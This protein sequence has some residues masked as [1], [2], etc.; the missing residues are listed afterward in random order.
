M[1]NIAFIG[2]GAMGKP[3]AR[4]ILKAGYS[5]TVFDLRQDVV[6]ELAGAGAAGAPTPREAAAGKDIVLLSLP[7]AAVVEQVLIAE[8]GLFAG[9]HP[10]QIFIDLSSVTP[11]HTRKMAQL[12]GEKGVGYLDA[13]V[14][15]G[16]AGAAAGTL[17][18][19]VGG[20]QAI[21]EKCREVLQTIGKKIYHVGPAGAGDTMKLIN[22]LLL[23]VNMAAVAEALTLG[24]K[25]ELDPATM[26]EIISVS[27]GR[28]YALEAKV[29]AFILKGNFAPGFAI[30]LQHKDLAM[31]IQTAKELAVPV[32]L[33]NTAQT[34]YETAQD[35]GLGGKD[36]SAV[37]TV[38]EKLAG[39]S[40]RA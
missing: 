27:S 32:D 33:A 40:V 3:I 25:A 26:L 11:A 13:P 19:M 24:V 31:A 34:M 14:S 39:I 12:A 37:I 18:I 30:D 28:S 8:D 38:L 15:G 16:V 7:N 23:G 6:K 22:N 20:E 36:I 17:T 2:L 9:S 4:N 1:K 10:G 29:P 21:L 35:N 5:L